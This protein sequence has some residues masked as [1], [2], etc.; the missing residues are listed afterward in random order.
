MILAKKLYNCFFISFT[1]LGYECYDY[2]DADRKKNLPEQEMCEKAG[3][4]FVFSRGEEIKAPG[5][6]GCWCCKPLCMD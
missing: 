4:G 5:C 3:V 6:D 1:A 2:N